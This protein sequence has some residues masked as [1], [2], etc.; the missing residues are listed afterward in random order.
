MGRVGCL[1]LGHT[2]S[3]ANPARDHVAALSFGAVW[4]TEWLCQ[5]VALSLSDLHTGLCSINLTLNHGLYSGG[6]V[7]KKGEPS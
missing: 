1:A 4:V 7:N 2:K 5:C 6:V 3:M